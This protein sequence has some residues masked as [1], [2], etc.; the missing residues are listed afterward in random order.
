MTD[1]TT[2][3]AHPTAFDAHHPP[4]D[5]IIDTCVHCG[6]CLPV[7]PTYV[8]WGQ[9]MDSPRGRIYLMKLAS[10]GAAAINPQWVSHFDS[11]LGCMACMP[12]CPSG[13]DY[14]K[15]IEATRAQIER[16]HKRSIREKLHRQ[17]ILSTF[18]RPDRLRLI[19]WPLLAYQKS[20]LQTLVRSAGL[21]K[22]L[23]KEMQAMEALL[24]NLS[25]SDPV[26]EITPAQG[27][28]RLRVGLL[29]GCVQR[30]FFPQINAATAR[31]LAAEGC[32][33]VAPQEQACCGA[34]L[35]HA[36]E[37]E[38]ALALARQTIDTFERANVEIIVTNA[39]GCG[40]S[41]NQYGHLLRDDPQYAARAVKFAAK[42]KDVSEILAELEPRAVRHALRVRVAFHDS[43]HLLHA[44]G[45]RSQ[46]RSLLSKIPDLD[47]AEIPESVI[48]CGSAGIYNLVQ[49]DTA[50]ALGDRKAQL[51]APLL[52]DVVATGNPGCLMQLQ[53]SLARGGHKTPVLHTIQ[54]LDAS[55]RGRG[56]DFL[57]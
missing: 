19:R 1:P 17:F 33:V 22:L 2:T 14:G 5:K 37:E 30:E 43:C 40:S 23:P 56:L 57:K 49:S 10:E 18:T 53:S 27:Q 31:V 41:V 26:A 51:I 24:P 8:L 36:G 48:C 29:L 16:K 20:G 50:N 39:A 6:F 32:E 38:A 21:L 46:P 11:C 15:L 55:I 13:V 42:C 52:A 54:L 4:S 3:S 28:K 35:V 45:V 7:C 12:A 44:Q 47:F 34:L 25:A 9:E